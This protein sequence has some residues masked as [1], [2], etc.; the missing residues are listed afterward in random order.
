MVTNRRFINC[1][2]NNPD[3]FNTEENSYENEFDRFINLDFEYILRM[4][5]EANTFFA[6]LNF[7]KSIELNS[8]ILKYIEDKKKSFIEIIRKKNKEILKRNKNKEE[9]NEENKEEKQDKIIREFDFTKSKTFPISIMSYNNRG[10]AYFKN[11]NFNEAISDFNNVIIRDK[12]NVKGYF[13]RGLA[14]LNL[15]IYDKALNDLT[16]AHKLT[17]NNEEKEQI[18]N[19]IDKTLNE[20]NSL[21]VSRKRKFENFEASKNTFFR[22]SLINDIDEDLIIQIKN[23]EERKSEDENNKYSNGKI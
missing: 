2:T 6:I 16:K 13:R 9:N 8:I 18:K 12:K 21:V 19:Q 10:N 15:Q 5:K 11:K 7:N 3:F 1:N 4:K 23:K 14:Y 22:N 17:D 20:I